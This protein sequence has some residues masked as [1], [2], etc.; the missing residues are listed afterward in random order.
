MAAAL[1]CQFNDGQP[2]VFVG[3][4]LEDG[5]SITVCIEHLVA[6]AQD[7]LGA[8]TDEVTS[9][10]TDEADPPIGDG[11]DSN[12]DAPSE[13]AGPTSLE[14]SDADTGADDADELDPQPAA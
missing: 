4:F 7:F 6:F 11:P 12:G 9:E 5:T 13:H 14:S 10:T 2:A 8:M 1:P 3:T